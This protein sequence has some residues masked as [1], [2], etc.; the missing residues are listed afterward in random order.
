MIHLFIYDKPSDTLILNLYGKDRIILLKK[1][2]YSYLEC[3]N[4]KIYITL[5]HIYL[6]V[7]GTVYETFAG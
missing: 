6:M 5:H 4:L 7:K 3:Q 2:I 1:T